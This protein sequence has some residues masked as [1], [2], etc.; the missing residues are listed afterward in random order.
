MS[1]LG[2]FRIP[3]VWMMSGWV[4]VEAENEL[5]AI[6]LA[7]GPEVPL[8]DGEYI[9]ESLEID[10][11]VIEVEQDE[12]MILFC[13]EFDNGDSNLYQ[14]T[15]VPSLAAARAFCKPY[16]D[17]NCEWNDVVR[18]DKIDREQAEKFWDLPAILAD[19]KWPIFRGPD[20]EF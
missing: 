10:G 15:R 12:Q 6:E 19:D 13:V 4:E 17:A 1:N 20:F 3:V 16:I 18:V 7:M 8:P 9:E 5:Q 14:G 2:K 11:D